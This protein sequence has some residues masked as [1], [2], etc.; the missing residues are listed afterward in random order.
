MGV[1]GDVF[2]EEGEGGAVGEIGGGVA[3]HGDAL[4]EA[5]GGAGED[6]ELEV[7]ERKEM[8]PL[9]LMAGV[10]KKTKLTPGLPGTG[11]PVRAMEV[12]G[13]SAAA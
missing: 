8:V 6:A 3:A 11:S 5:A 12:R 9:A 4:N 1:D 10:P 2:V 7:W 13:M